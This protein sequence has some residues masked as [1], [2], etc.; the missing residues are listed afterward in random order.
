MRSCAECKVSLICLSLGKDSL[1]WVVCRGCEYRFLLIRS[2]PI[3]LTKQTLE[4]PRDCPNTDAFVTQC[5]RCQE[6]VKSETPT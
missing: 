6:E 5:I 3:D 2:F 4:T 1:E